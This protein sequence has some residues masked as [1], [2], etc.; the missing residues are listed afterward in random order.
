VASCIS[1]D[2]AVS[3]S[4]AITS[5]HTRRSGSLSLGTHCTIA[6]VDAKDIARARGVASIY[7]L[8]IVQVFKTNYTW[9]IAITKARAHTSQPWKVVA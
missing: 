4:F 9:T 5:G 8:D 3:C 7:T 2:Q 1:Y 6:C